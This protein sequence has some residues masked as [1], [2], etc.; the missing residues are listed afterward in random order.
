MATFHVV[1]KLDFTI[2]VVDFGVIQVIKNFLCAMFVFWRGSFHVFK[3][4]S[5]VKY[6]IILSFVYR[7]LAVNP[8]GMFWIINNDMYRIIGENVLNNYQDIV[9]TSSTTTL[10][11]NIVVQGVMMKKKPNVVSPNSKVSSFINLCDS[12]DE[13]NL[14]IP[15]V[16]ILVSMNLQVAEK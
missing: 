8:R 11:A 15:I 13:D 16:V 9:L 14:A 10:V 6:N 2:L 3:D 1:G 4:V 5:Y 12:F 7:V